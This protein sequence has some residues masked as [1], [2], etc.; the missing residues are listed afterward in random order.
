MAATNR[1][2]CQSCSAQG[3]LVPSRAAEGTS[4][5]TLSWDLVSSRLAVLSDISLIYV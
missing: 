2:T 1:D 5:V 3:A 4:A